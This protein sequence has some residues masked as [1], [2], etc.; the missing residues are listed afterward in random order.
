MR[1]F[2]DARFLIYLNTLCGERRK[3]FE[4]F[5]EKLLEEEPILNVI[6]LDETLYISRRKEIWS[7]L[8]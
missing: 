7:T 4:E 5:W 2:V 3:L 6:V 8:P 1:V